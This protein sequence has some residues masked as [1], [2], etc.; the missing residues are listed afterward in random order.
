MSTR[1]AAAHRRDEKEPS[2]NGLKNVLKS[3]REY[4]NSGLARGR[5][6]ARGLVPVQPPCPCHG[7]MIVERALRPALP[8]I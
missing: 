8:H 1:T 5:A 4:A 7:E 2:A 3:I 6:P